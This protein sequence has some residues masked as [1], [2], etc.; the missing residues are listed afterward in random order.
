MA[1]KTEAERCGKKVTVWKSLFYITGKTATHNNLREILLI[2]GNVQ[3]NSESL[4]EPGLF[5]LHKSGEISANWWLI[6]LSSDK[7]KA[8]FSF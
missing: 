3:I 5:F 7:Y 4:T 2:V 1:N 8:D 6:I